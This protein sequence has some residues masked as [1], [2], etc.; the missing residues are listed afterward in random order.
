MVFSSAHRTVNTESLFCLTSSEFG[1]IELRDL[2]SLGAQSASTT[3]YFLIV[4]G[5][6]VEVAKEFIDRLKIAEDR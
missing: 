4:D 5:G 1:W 6:R 3:A 2:C